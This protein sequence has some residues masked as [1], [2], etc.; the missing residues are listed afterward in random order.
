MSQYISGFDYTHVE[1]SSD[2]DYAYLVE[3]G[4]ANRVPRPYFRPAVNQFEP[5]FIAALR[6]CL[7]K[8]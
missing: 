3:Y 8:D 6:A 5:I 1:I 2:L 4:S 7:F